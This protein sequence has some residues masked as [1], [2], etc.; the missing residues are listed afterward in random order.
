MT[1][2]AGAAESRRDPELRTVMLRKEWNVLLN[3]QESGGEF[4]R[5]ERAAGVSSTQVGHFKVRESGWGG[6]GWGLRL[7]QK[8]G[9]KSGGSHVPWSV[10]W[11]WV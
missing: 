4:R 11:W 2:R 8:Q 9:P 1:G 7:N 6:G 3:Q 10:K 5:Y